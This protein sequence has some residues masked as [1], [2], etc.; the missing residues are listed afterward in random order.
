MRSH[1]SS[2]VGA[3]QNLPPQRLKSREE[4]QTN[5]HEWYFIVKTPDK[6]ARYSR[7]DVLKELPN[8]RSKVF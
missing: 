8:L 6:F 3:V 2:A 4:K 1:D 5:K 7:Q